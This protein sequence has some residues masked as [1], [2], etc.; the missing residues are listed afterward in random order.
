LTAV[1]GGGGAPE[2]VLSLPPR[3]QANFLAAF[4][5]AYTGLYSC[6][7]YVFDRRGLPGWPY[8][9][10][11]LVIYTF[12][13][14]PF[15]F[16]KLATLP[17]IAARVASRLGDL[18]SQTSVPAQIAIPPSDQGTLLS[19]KQSERP[20]SSRW[21]LRESILVQL[22][23]SSIIV[24]TAW[25]CTYS[26]GPFQSPYGQILLALPLL[27]PNIAAKSNSIL[28]VYA[29]SAA[30]ALLFQFAFTPSASTPSMSW[31]V[32]TTVGVLAVSAYVSWVTRR[33]QEQVVTAQLRSPR[34]SDDE[35]SE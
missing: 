24:M 9:V 15:Y 11:L 16:S 10:I 29:A 19:P 28:G 30:S 7:L 21:P 18:L 8:F 17:V 34:R 27:S 23:A 26:G 25:Y 22:L 32:W 3:M 12:L 5:L 2:V 33:R 1:V 6:A 4:S 35:P 13:W 20:V 14:G 31:Y